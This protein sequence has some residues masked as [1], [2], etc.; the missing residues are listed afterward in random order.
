LLAVQE[1]AFV[2]DHVK[3]TGACATLTVGFAASE[4]VSPAGG[5]EIVTACCAVPPA[6]TQT[7]EYVAVAVSGPMV[8]EPLVGSDPDH[9]PPA[10]QVVALV[11]DQVRVASPPEATVVALADRETVGVAG[12]EVPT[13]TTTVCSTLPPTP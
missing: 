2:D 11:L 4:T 1:V 7:S 8:C 12:V 13:V 9:P 5:T 10:A 6:P 3:V